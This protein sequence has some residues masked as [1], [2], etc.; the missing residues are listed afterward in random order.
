MQV[1]PV[2]VGVT[3][4]ERHRG[5]LLGRAAV[6]GHAGAGPWPERDAPL[7]RCRREA[8]QR[9][10]L[11]G[12]RVRCT[13]LLRRR[14]PPTLQE[15]VDPLRDDGHDRRHVVPREAATRM[16]PQPLAVV[17]EHPIDHQR[18]DMDI[19]IQ[20]A[21]EALND[22]DGPAPAVRHALAPRTEKRYDGPH[23]HAHHR[24]TQLVIPCKPVPQ[25]SGQWLRHAQSTGAPRA[26]ARYRSI[27]R[28]CRDRVSEVAI[29]T[30]V[31]A[32]ASDRFERFVGVTDTRP[33]PVLATFRPYVR[34][35]AGPQT[36]VASGL[37]GP[38]P[39]CI[40]GPRPRSSTMLIPRRCSGRP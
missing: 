25:P 30:T 20:G 38:G 32:T 40:H 2:D 11:V 35:L 39:R 17:R 4:A 34:V 27:R 28:G 8:R 26:N 33:R 23:E 6:P 5:S 10:R 19:Q 7:N 21:A 3:R 12:P 24:A 22:R 1:E 37:A 29:L 14:Q 15:P 18:M 16:K 9:R 36:P 31:I 13:A